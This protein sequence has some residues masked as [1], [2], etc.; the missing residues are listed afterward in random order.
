MIQ[1]APASDHGRILSPCKL[2]SRQILTNLQGAAVMIN[3]DSAG[4][5]P[6]AVKMSVLSQSYSAARTGN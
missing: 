6:F 1:A 5:N 3:S 4:S 2:R